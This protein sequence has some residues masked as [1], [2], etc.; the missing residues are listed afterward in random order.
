MCTSILKAILAG[1]HLACHDIIGAQWAK[2]RGTSRQVIDHCAKQG[3]WATASSV[4]HRESFNAKAVGDEHI[5]RKN[6]TCA[7]FPFDNCDF[8]PRIGERQGE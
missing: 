7:A 3:M 8:D 1:R 2:S 6:A 5:L 4:E